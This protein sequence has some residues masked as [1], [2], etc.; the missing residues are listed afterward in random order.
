MRKNQDLKLVLDNVDQGFITIDREARIVGER[1]RI[2]DVWLGSVALEQS[3]WECLD[4]VSPGVRQNFR[5]CWNEVIEAMMPLEVTLYQMPQ[6][7]VA[8]GRH[9]RLEYKPLQAEGD[10]FDKMLV[11]LSD[12]TAQVERE[13]SEQEERDILN[14]TSRLLQDR[15][16]FMEFFTETANLV[17][18]IVANKSDS[19]TLKRDLHTLKGNTA[20]YGLLRLSHLCHELETELESLEPS[21]VD[22]SQLSVQWERTCAKLKVV[23]GE[24]DQSSISVDEKEYNAVL[25]AVKRGAPNSSIRPLI[26]SWRLEPMVTRLNRVG[27]QLAKTV[28]RIGKGHVEVDVAAPRVYMAR[29]ELAEFWSVFSHVVR[30]AAVHGLDSAEERAEQ[31]KPIIARFGLNAGVDSGRFFIELRDS[32]P[33]VDWERVRARAKEKGLPTATQADLER[34]IFTDGISTENSV[35]ETAGRGVGLSAVR[36]VCLRQGG[37]IQVTS[38]RGKGAAFRFSWPTA[39]LRTLTVLEGA[40]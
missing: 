33:G 25:D 13:R 38:T 35:S 3:L 8:N 16:G 37:S 10:E 5:V 9:F 6:R 24:G 19:V 29:E 22:C 2:I 36:E 34:A 40:A 17:K 14:M 27:E 31:G 26:E 11:I 12:V 28:E 32:G 23:L 7:L 30:N 18:R 1:S 39:R 15:S 4:R 21:E 20:I